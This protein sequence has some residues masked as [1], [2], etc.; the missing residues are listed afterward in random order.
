MSCTFYSKVTIATPSP[1][2]P[3]IFLDDTI[4]NYHDPDYE[5]KVEQP[6]CSILCLTGFDRPL[7][8]ARTTLQKLLIGADLKDLH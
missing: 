4:S 2:L 7:E 6:P 8:S 1:S 3:R 5:D